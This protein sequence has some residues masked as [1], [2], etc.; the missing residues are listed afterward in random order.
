VAKEEEI[1]M[2]VQVQRTEEQVWEAALNRAL[3]EALDVLVEPLSG[4]AFVESA[5]TP[6][7]LYIVTA[8]SCSCPAGER[9]IPCKHAAA[10]RAQTGLLALPAPAACVECCGCGMQS[11]GTYDLPCETCGG[12]GVRQ[13]R[14]LQDAPAIQPVAAAA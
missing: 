6:G 9:G 2:V 10:Y 14:R 8:S 13:D 11:Y 5:T 3:E 1:A 4:Q 7:T 12:S